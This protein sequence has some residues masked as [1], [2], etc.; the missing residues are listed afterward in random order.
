MTSKNLKILAGMISV[1]ALCGCNESI[2]YGPDEIECNPYTYQWSCTYD[3]Q[4]LKKCVDNKVV[5]ELCAFG[6][7][8]ARCKT[9]QEGNPCD[10][11]TFVNSCADSYTLELCSNGIVTTQLC[12]KGCADNQCRT[13]TV[14]PIPGPNPGTNP[15]GHTAP[16]VES[17]G[18]LTVSGTN[19]CEKTGSGS[20]IVLRGDVLALNKT[21]AGGSVVI[22]NNRIT[23]V[24][25]DPDISGA[26]VITCPDSVIS[27]GLVNAHDHITYSNATPD[28]WGDERFDHRMDWRKNAYGHTNHNGDSTSDNEVGELR[29][30]MS[31]VTSL[32]GSGKLEG[33]VRNLDKESV[34][35]VDASTYQTFPL[36]DSG[37]TK[38]STKCTQYNYKT[39]TNENDMA[40]TANYGPHIGEGINDTALLELKCLSGEGNGSI[41]IFKSN[42]AIIHGVA[43]T[44][45]IMALMAERKSKLIWSA[46]TNISLYGDTANVVAY[47]TLGVTIALGTDWI[48]SGSANMLREFACVNSL[49][50]LY[51]NNHFTD[52]DIWKMATVNGAEALGFGSVIGQLKENYLADIA[53]Y[54]KDNGRSAHAAVTKAE[55]KDVQLVMI[56][57]VIAF[58]DA[59][60]V[61][62][63]ST[64]GT[65]TIGGVQKK[66]CPNGT[67]KTY[68]TIKSSSKY[69]LFF[70]GTP[71]A[72][73][74]CIPQRTRPQDTT[75]QGTTQYDGNLSDNFSD[76]NDTDGDGIPNA[77]DNCPN[78]FNPI[79][80]QDK[81]NVSIAAQGDADDD[82]IGDACDL[83]PLCASNNSSCPVFNTK[84][85]DNDGVDSNL[86]NCPSIANPQQEDADQDGIGDACDE[87]PNDKNLADGR[88][89][90]NTLSTIPQVNAAILQACPDMNSNCTSEGAEYKTSGRVTAVYKYGF[91]MQTPD[92]SEP[93]NGLYIYTGSAPT[94]IMNDDVTVQGKLSCYYGLN[95]ISSPF[96][97]KTGTGSEVQ[98][99]QINGTN[100]R[101]Y[102]G[103]LARFANITISEKVQGK[104]STGELV[105]N[106]YAWKFTTI[107]TDDL[108]LGNYLWTIDPEPEV[109]STYS[110]A[111][112]VILMNN[113]LYRLAPRDSLDLPTGDIPLALASV[114]ASVSTAVYGSEIN[115]TIYMTQNVESNTTVTV[116]CGSAVCPSTAVIP[117]GSSSVTIPVTMAASGNTTVT[118]TYDDTSKST[119]ITGQDSGSNPPSGQFTASHNM[120]FAN[121]RDLAGSEVASNNYE[122]I[123]VYNLEN[124]IVVTAKGAFKSS[125]KTGTQ[126]LQESDLATAIVMDGKFSNYIEVTNLDG[127]GTVS[128]VYVNWDSVATTV[129]T[130]TNNETKTVVTSEVSGSATEKTFTYDFNDSAATSFKIQPTAEGG[131]RKRIVIKSLTWTS[132]K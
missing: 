88:C 67:S 62:D 43:A 108:H 99:V 1:L 128:F 117:A 112:G 58:G 30:L 23:Y 21:Y 53:I 2:E 124:N 47:D 7:D 70:E 10:E 27:P 24:G 45:A 120:T 102:Q 69:P 84:D 28:N 98:P 29:M 22:E 107:G 34:G 11:A 103:M 72:E 130:S 57:G 127:V 56:D 82:G 12:T 122:T 79:R 71:N 76:P 42:L 91:F 113:S 31:G 93:N 68:S 46:R 17:C 37:D 54:H 9:S 121:A 81:A 18:T 19:A 49:N 50:Q 26:T 65:E 4:N 95:Q 55:N 52:Y 13:T 123:A 129:N 80:P 3:G 104:K 125:G 89:P 41:D 111:T 40:K 64:C 78:I 90:V 8:D 73:P 61:P 83:Y 118:V 5:L 119:T 15:G 96:V 74:T 85:T 14:D 131:S 101:S 110:L 51:Y 116:Q 16:A 59:N 63:G 33:L 77:Q 44:P 105:K 94:V 66:I 32:Y 87:C 38:Y 20:K 39:V 48:Y 114:A 75:D 109:G 60:L 126:G 86:D 97:E 115:V 106:D 132:K 100:L 35:G 25:C 36:G 92:T 6:C